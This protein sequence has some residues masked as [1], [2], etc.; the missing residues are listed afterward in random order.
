[1]NRLNLS[2]LLTLYRLKGYKSA[3][4]KGKGSFLFFFCKNCC[5]RWVDGCINCP[6][7]FSR[8]PSSIK[9]GCFGLP[10]ICRLNITLSCRV[11]VSRFMKTPKF[12]KQK[13]RNTIS[14]PLL[15]QMLRNFRSS[16]LYHCT[17]KPI[18]LIFFC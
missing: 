3:L 5:S 14:Q 6:L 2:D 16:Y 13:V 15:N 8:L 9:S 18:N 10:K 17:S 1:M 12:D 4:C 7:P 11:H